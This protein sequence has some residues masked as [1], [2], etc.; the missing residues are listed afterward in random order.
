MLDQLSKAERLLLLKF[1]CAFAWADLEVRDEEREFV[2][3]LVRG[4]DLSAD[5]AEQV[6]Q[7]LEVAPRPEEVDPNQV[8]HKHR[9]IFLDAARKMITSDGM[10]DEAELENYDLFKKLLR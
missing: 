6:E 8:P 3:K 9:K 1:V 2:H 4:L 10:I 7:W 5:E